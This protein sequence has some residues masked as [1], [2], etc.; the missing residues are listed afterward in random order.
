MPDKTYELSRRKALLGL[1]TIGV[2]GAAAGMG[3]SALFTDEEEFENNSFTAGTL[4]MS[5]T[6]DVVAANQYWE[7]VANL[8]MA[9]ADGEVETGLQ[10]GDVKPGDWVIICFTI[11]IGENPGYVYVSI[12]DFV[13][14]ENGIDDPEDDED[15]SL[16]D[17]ELDEKLLATVWDDYNGNGARDGLSTLDV[18]TNNAASLYPDSAS[19][20]HSWDSSRSEGGEVDNDIHYTTIR[21]AY[22]EEYDDGF[23]LGPGPTTDASKIGGPNTPGHDA[24]VFYLLLE[25]PDEVGNE[26]QSDSVGFDLIFESEQV[27][28]NDN[29]FS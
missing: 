5:V 27:R 18:T 22:N 4:N 26:I 11:E 9:T 1:G 14:N 12:D 29:P 16:S 13:D 20:N 19:T 10:V 3:T 7:D 17:G 8:S 6:A 15:S 24:K 28:N 21:E 2:A 25:V 23:L